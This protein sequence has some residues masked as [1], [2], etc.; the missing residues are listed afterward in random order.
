MPGLGGL[1]RTSSVQLRHPI[2]NPGTRALLKLLHLMGDQVLM[3][4]L[5]L[6][7]GFP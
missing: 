4:E 1:S 5:P 3:G 6:A 2:P 7:E